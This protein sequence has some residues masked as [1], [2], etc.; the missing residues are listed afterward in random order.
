MLIRS[1]STNAQLINGLGRF[2]NGVWIM[3]PFMKL[4]R[5]FLRIQIGLLK[6][7]NL[8]LSKKFLFSVITNIFKFFMK[9]PLTLYQ[10][11]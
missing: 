2:I 3:R 1:M 11:S 9:H 8:F 7:L 6:T 10:M 5:L 4:C